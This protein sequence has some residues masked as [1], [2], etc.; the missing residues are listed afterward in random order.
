ML[1]TSPRHASS[2]SAR[3]V[4]VRT[5]L[6]AVRKRLWYRREMRIYSCHGKKIL[7]LPR[8][9]LF[10][11]NC[12]EDLRRYEACD[13]W[14]LPI[15]EY[16]LE[17]YRRIKLG[18]HLYTLVLDGR[19]AFY[20]WLAE[21]EHR[22]E[23]PLLGQVWFPPADSSVIFDCYTHP[24]VRGQGLYYHALCQMLHDAL[25][26]CQAE[27]VCIGSLAD[28]V[29]S[30]HVIEKIGFRY[31]GSMI[32]KGRFFMLRRYALAADAQFR[33]ALL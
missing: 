12:F 23:D 15:E 9:R 2:T 20:G 30:R 17:S 25:D 29:A 3:S 28:N 32:K 19:L 31:N 16:R 24:V 7:D 4:S 1:I 5:L 26:H 33:A 27:Q 8:P 18:Y 10:R 13:R 6:L 21:R 14:Q 22:H 11:R